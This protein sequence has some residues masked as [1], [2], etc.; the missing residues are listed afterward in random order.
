MRRILLKHPKSLALATSPVY[1]MVI[2]LMYHSHSTV[3]VLP[4]L[5]L[6]YLNIYSFLD[7]LFRLNQKSRNV[8]KIKTY[9]HASNYSSKPAKLGFQ[10]KYFHKCFVKYFDFV[11]NKMVSVSNAWHWN[12]LVSRILTWFLETIWSVLK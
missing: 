8:V 3:I 4:V 10:R 2:V 1:E 6:L 7:S 5:N 11:T 9:K 12:I